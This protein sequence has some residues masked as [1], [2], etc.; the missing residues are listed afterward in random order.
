MQD[1]ITLDWKY[2]GMQ[3]FTEL[4]RKYQG[5]QTFTKFYWI[6]VNHEK[7]SQNLGS[8]LDNFWFFCHLSW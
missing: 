1:S 6:H 4:E 8:N 7:T 3:D 2:H 5:M